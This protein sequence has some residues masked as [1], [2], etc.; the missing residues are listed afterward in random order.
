VYSPF[1]KA[2]YIT[3]VSV[4][5]ILRVWA[6]YH[7]S[8]LILAILL[9]VYVV[10]TILNVTVSIVYSTPNRLQGMLALVA[11]SVCCA[12]Q[13]VTITVVSFGQHKVLVAHVF[14]ITVC[15]VQPLSTWT[16]AAVIPELVLGVAMCTLLI[17]RFTREA[18]QM[19][20]TTKQLKVNRYINLFVKEGIL[21]FL[22]CV[23]VWSY[24]PTSR[25]Q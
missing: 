2:I 8:R 25:Q 14:N 4:A 15:V 16:R 22:V 9:T 7:Q 24:L 3:V 17:V 6:T 12:N 19:Y 20:K 13:F 23:L 21:Y 18:L 10:E 1:R 11:C 5:M